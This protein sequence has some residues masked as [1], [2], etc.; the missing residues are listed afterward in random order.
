MEVNKTC[1]L[2]SFQ[3][4]EVKGHKQYVKM[5]YQPQPG[6]DLILDV[7]ARPDPDA[8]A[9]RQEGMMNTTYG[10][11]LG[12]INGEG[13]VRKWGVK[14]G[15]RIAY[16]CPPGAV[17]AVIFLTCIAQ[18]C[19]V[20][21]DRRSTLNEMK[22]SMEQLKA[23][24]YV[25]FEGVLLPDEQVKMEE[26]LKEMGINCIY[27]TIPEGTKAGLFRVLDNK[28][29][30]DMAEEPLRT[31]GTTPVCMLRTSGT[32]S[33]P[34]A[35][36]L[37]QADII[38]NGLVLAEVIGIRNT[39]INLNIMPLFHIGGLSCCVLASLTKG[40]SLICMDMFNLQAFFDILE[41]DIDP[42]TWY[43]A[44]PSVHDSILMY[45]REG[46]LKPKHSLRLIRSGAAKLRHETA[47]GLRD[48]FGGIPVYPTYS[49][50][51][52]M[53]I[54]Q[55]PRDYRLEKEDSVGVPN[56]CSMVIIDESKTPL[57]FDI[58][59]EVCISGPN[60]LKN[61]ANNP[62]ANAKSYFEYDG[63]RFFRTG[64]MGVLDKDGYL[65]LKGRSKELIKRGGE[66]VSPFEV[67]ECVN[68]VPF[69]DFSLCFAVPSNLWGEEV[70]IVLIL[71]AEIEARDHAAIV[72]EVKRHCQE[73]LT[74]Y[75]IPQLIWILDR[76]DVATAIPKTTTGKY[77]RGGLYDA[78]KPIMDAGKNPREHIIASP[79]I[80]GAGYLMSVYIVFNHC[81]GTSGDLGFQAVDNARTLY[82]HVAAFMILGGLSM[83][84]GS[85]G[86]E[87][88]DFK[89]WYFS[90]F[91]SL[92]P[93]YIISVTLALIHWLSWCHPSNFV[94]EFDYSPNSRCMTPYSG[95]GYGTTLFLSTVVYVLGLQSW[96]PVFLGIWFFAPYTWFLSCYFFAVLVFPYVYNAFYR[97]QE[98]VTKYIGLNFL[99]EA[100]VC[101]VFLPYFSSTSD[102]DRFMWINHLYLLPPL[103]L[104]TFCMGI[105]VYFALQCYQST[106][107]QIWDAVTD[108]ISVLMGIML[109]LLVTAREHFGFDIENNDAFPRFW[110]M[111]LTHFWS[112]I[113]CIW[114]YGLCVGEGY[115][116]RICKTEALQ[117]LG[118]LSYGVFLFH[119]SVI[120]WYLLVTRGEHFNEARPYYFFTPQPADVQWPEYILVV[121]LCTL[122][123]WFVVEYINPIVFNVWLS[124]FS[125]ISGEDH[126]D[127]ELK[128]NIEGC[129]LAIFAQVTGQQCTLEDSMAELGL[130]SLRVM[131][132]YQK[133]IKEYDD[134]DLTLND[135]LMA[136][137]VK[138]VCDVIASRKK[139][140]NKILV[141]EQSL[142][143]TSTVRSIGSVY[144]KVS[145]SEQ[146]HPARSAPLK[147]VGSS[148]LKYRKTPRNGEGTKQY[149]DVSPMSPYTPGAYFNRKNAVGASLDSNSFQF[150]EVQT[151]LTPSS[152]PENPTSPIRS[153]P[154]PLQSYRSFTSR[155]SPTKE[156]TTIAELREQ[157][158]GSTA[159]AIYEAMSPG[160]ARSIRSPTYKT[161]WPHPSSPAPTLLSAMSSRR[162]TLR[163]KGYK[164][165]IT[166]SQ[167]FD[168]DDDVSYEPLNTSVGAGVPVQLPVRT[169]E[170]ED[171]GNLV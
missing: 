41:R 81:G 38:Q 24:H 166:P 83:A 46:N 130:G 169:F 25:S 63:M 30:D 126:M 88:T 47:T 44:V 49:M 77:K 6:Y 111:L 140:I 26:M 143:L 90:M 146:L 50:S 22:D 99:A 40:A 131:F 86:Q 12:F 87:I 28:N 78:L 136:Y 67:E 107:P 23:K 161:V 16:I 9:L 7:L 154:A 39:D 125:Y 68:K 27:V 33:R 113:L 101:L 123:S 42:P 2:S 112:P 65:T 128:G 158:S 91:S 94:D 96:S 18:T 109:V 155:T 165:T 160:F 89:S 82:L 69:V 141:R 129:V 164:L 54:V 142:F 148:S 15:E 4:F 66:Q 163:K 71:D 119:D 144:H 10:D 85:R 103:W 171:P 57:P 120:N 37:L 45:A 64:D 117:F 56:C 59:G 98:S 168:H 73:N 93:L 159:H 149:D 118:R 35:V 156:I 80:L 157:V 52:Q 43:H 20:P 162:S 32:T 139:D 31:I 14:D 55:P 116:A 100:V 17:G 108:G 72:L 60:V 97:N 8:V 5:E 137:T 124:A 135:I 1:R 29:S 138:E 110:G 150:S 132:L 74:S 106:N 122:F 114:L 70:G 13:D 127:E 151:A 170:I 145:D 95:W 51:E 62:E 11:L 92:Y 48:F 152:S 61:Y 84:I 3:S 36:P 34:K 134:I 75:K 104:P 102:A 21:L 115:T 19:A 105:S 58:P 133:L 53:P 167:S 153:R 147:R 76:E 79:A 121:I